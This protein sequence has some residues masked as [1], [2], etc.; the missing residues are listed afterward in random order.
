MIYW[1]ITSIVD[2]WMRYYLNLMTVLLTQRSSFPLR[3]LG[4]MIYI[5]THFLNDPMLDFY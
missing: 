5:Y 2:S 3:D 4:L 1:I